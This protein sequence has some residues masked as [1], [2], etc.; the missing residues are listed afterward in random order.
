MEITIEDIRKTVKEALAEENAAGIQPMIIPPLA[1]G[2]NT[3]PVKPAQDTISMLDLIDECLLYKADAGAA[4]GYLKV[5]KRK[6]RFFA[7]QY[8]QLPTEP[9]AIRTY[10]RQFKTADGLPEQP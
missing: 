3:E 1:T 8:P 4:E 9:E 10:L 7:R 2:G 6:L 5:R